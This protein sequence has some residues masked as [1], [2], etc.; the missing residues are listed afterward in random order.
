MSKMHVVQVTRPNGPLE[1]VEREIP[2]PDAGQVRIKVEACG[3]CHSD[4]FTKEGTWPGIQYP[5]VPGHEVAGSID[6]VGTG[7]VGWRAGQRV[8]VGWHGGH[9]GYC[10]SCR[11]G[12]FVTCQIALQIPGIAYDGG[13]AEYMIVPAGALALIPEGLS[14]AEAG[15][16]MCA[17]V[18]TFNPLRNSGA[19]PGDLVAILGIG[20]LG[21][22]GIQFAAKMGFTTVA[23]ARGMDKE[24]LSRQLGA[25]H[26]IDSRTQDTAAELLKLGAAK[27][28]L[29]TVTSGKAMSMA[30]GGLSVNGKLIVVGAADEPLEV[31]GG[32]MLMGRRS[33]MGWPSGNSIDSQDTLSFS[34]LAGVRSINEIFPLDRAA[35]AYEH[36]MSG[37]ARFRAVLTIGHH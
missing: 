35:E 4:S 6:A 9:C 28:I 3:I 25:S 19:R 34:R 27:V 15:P 31:H 36:M 5:R 17:G 24:P 13:Y 32:L 22:L 11:R 8:G 10:D 20:G 21:H 7:V 12:D 26:Y 23:I 37:K 16:L 29:A 14:A 1:I 18:T 33:I 30:L 2:E